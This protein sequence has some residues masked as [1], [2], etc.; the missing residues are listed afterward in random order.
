MSYK[1]MIKGE[2]KSLDKKLSETLDFALFFM[3]QLTSSEDNRDKGTRFRWCWTRPGG[4]TRHPES[5]VGPQLKANA[6]P[7]LSYS[8]R[9]VAPKFLGGRS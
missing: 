8:R 6:Y 2:K 4:L 5:L 7:L 1:P 9:A 3:L